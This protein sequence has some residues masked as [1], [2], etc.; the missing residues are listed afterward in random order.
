MVEPQQESRSA[1]LRDHGSRCDVPRA[2][3]NAEIE[4]FKNPPWYPLYEKRR[5]RSRGSVKIKNKGGPRRT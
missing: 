2:F 3:W 4:L 5:Q 1:F